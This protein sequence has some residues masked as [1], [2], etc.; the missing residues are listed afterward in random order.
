MITSYYGRKIPIEESLDQL[1]PGQDGISAAEIV[2][3]ARSVG[4]QAKG[5]RTEPRNLR[6]LDTPFIVHWQ[7]N[8]FLVVERWKS[9]QIVVIDPAIGRRQVSVK[10]FV[11]GFTGTVLNFS[12]C[13]D[14]ESKGD[15]T[16]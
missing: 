9:D 7:S 8:H 3:E 11:E 14:E 1:S 2:Q 10:Q 4:L 15:G 6:Y 5:Y 13:P 16:T 12:L